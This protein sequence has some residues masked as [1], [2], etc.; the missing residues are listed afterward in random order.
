MSLT[1]TS[2]L[3][4][5]TSFAF[6]LGFVLSSA[7]L[8]SSN[9]TSVS[10]VATRGVILGALISLFAVVALALVGVAVCDM[11]SGMWCGV[12]PKCCATCCGL[13]PLRNNPTVS[14]PKTAWKRLSLS[15]RGGPRSLS[16]PA[17]SNGP[18][19]AGSRVTFWNPSFGAPPLELRGQRNS[20]GV[21]T[22][23]TDKG[24]YPKDHSGAAHRS[25]GQGIFVATGPSFR[26]QT[27]NP[28]GSAAQ[29]S[30][31]HP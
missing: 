28:V 2:Q 27:F 22:P 5:A 16:N 17:G 31:S 1:G 11:R 19:L 25:A 23:D 29:S 4:R 20:F 14:S 26:S 8:P 30:R 12:R 9:A 13:C 6:M 15:G 7:Q 18:R 21:P 24:G 10:L 3:S